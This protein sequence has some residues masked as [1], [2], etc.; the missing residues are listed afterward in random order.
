MSK[1][2]FKSLAFVDEWAEI[3]RIDC[4]T[5]KEWRDELQ[6]RK[7]HT[8]PSWHS[9]AAFPRKRNWPLQGKLLHIGSE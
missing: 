3:D 1:N 2:S 7:A 9:G 5:P 6:Y 4:V 8:Y